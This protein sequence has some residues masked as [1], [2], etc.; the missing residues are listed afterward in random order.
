[1]SGEVLSCSNLPVRGR[2]VVLADVG[3]GGGV[4]ERHPLCEMTEEIK[5]SLK[6]NH[7]QDH[8]FFVAALQLRNPSIS[9]T[10]V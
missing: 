8:F 1:M 10:C 4:E 5:F 7:I 3:K 2:S 9:L 6:N